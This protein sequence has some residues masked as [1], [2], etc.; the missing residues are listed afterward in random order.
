MHWEK[1]LSSAAEGED[2]LVQFANGSGVGLDERGFCP[3]EL[4]C[5]PIQKEQGRYCFLG[6]I[7]NTRQ[8]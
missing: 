8:L 7:D 5:K 1:M 3:V 2:C 6:L 4:K